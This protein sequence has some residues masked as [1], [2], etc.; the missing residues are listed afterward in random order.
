MSQPT[1]ASNERAVLEASLHELVTW[2]ANVG[3]KDIPAPIFQRAA[4]VLFDD[5]SAMIGAW[6][7]PEFRRLYPLLF[8]ST[9]P[10]S[11]SIF[12]DPGTKADVYTAALVNAVS[13]NWLELDEGFRLT[14]CHAGLYVLPALL[15]Q[16]ET[17]GT[18]TQEMLTTLVVSYEVITRIARAF[19]QQPSVMQSHGRFAAVGAAIATARH[20][21]LQ[22]SQMADAINSASTLITPA[23]R[24][25]LAEGALVRNV[26]AGLGAQSGLRAAEWVEAGITG[27]PA[28]LY[29]VYVTVLR[30]GFKPEELTKGL[31]TSWA[32]EHGYTKIYACCQHL[33]AAVQAALE[34]RPDLMERGLE[35]IEGIKVYTHE[36]ALP[37]DNSSPTN[38]LSAK[39]SMSHALAS[40][41][42]TGTGGAEAFNTSTLSN[43]QIHQLRERISMAP[44]PAPIPA[45]PNDRPARLHIQLDDGSEV[46]AECLSARG[47]SDQPLT[48]IERHEKVQQLTHSG[49]PELAALAAE[50]IGGNESYTARPWREVVA[51]MQ[52]KQ[53]KQPKQA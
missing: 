46:V 24:N 53:A 3:A 41:L 23:P 11:A 20:K 2:A 36:L 49:Y 25:H 45:S 34:H 43:P 9:G 13:A 26:W 15:A 4:E 52:P 32:V 40:V 38:T 48:R 29:D 31:G 6:A 35:K 18:T 22:P 7:E 42:V 14:P 21:G 30:G 12:C 44:W 33:H 47:G 50:V 1:S 5:L 19:P 8:K 28:S 51:L 37:L 39:F 10:A 27:T 17:D 16:A